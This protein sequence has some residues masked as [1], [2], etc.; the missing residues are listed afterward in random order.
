MGDEGLRLPTKNS[1]K[2]T[3][4]TSGDAKSDAV[5]KK[6]TVEELVQMI[7]KHYKQDEVDQLTSLLSSKCETGG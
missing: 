5:T 2:T 1:G 4:S 3:I 7:R 6:P